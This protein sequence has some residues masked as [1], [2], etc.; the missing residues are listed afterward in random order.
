MPSGRSKASSA[1]ASARDVRESRAPSAHPRWQTRGSPRASSARRGRRNPRER[2]SP[3]RRGASEVRACRAAVV[4]RGRARCPVAAARANAGVEAHVAP[5]TGRS[6]PTTPRLFVGPVAP[7]AVRVAEA[8]E[9]LAARG[10]EDIRAEEA[11]VMACAARRARSLVRAG[12]GARRAVARRAVEERGGI[13]RVAA[14]RGSRWGPRRV[15]RDGSRTVAPVVNERQIAFPSY[16]PVAAARAWLATGPMASWHVRQVIPS[17]EPGDR[18]SRSGARVSPGPRALHAGTVGRSVSA[19]AWQRMHHP[20]PPEPV[21][22]SP[23][24]S[25]R[26][27]SPAAA[28]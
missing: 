6:R 21:T 13:E 1:G 26:H 11:H 9:V 28:D 12:G 20:S 25:D 17:S 14:V 22:V 8:L 19:G 27:A 5:L 18:R 7:L 16:A 2:K 3:R 23:V 4:P 15:V 24:G 10:T